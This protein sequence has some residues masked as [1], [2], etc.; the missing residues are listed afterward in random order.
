MRGVIRVLL[1]VLLVIMA[2][3]VG[4]QDELVVEPIDVPQFALSSV[5]P[6]G[7]TALGNGL[8]SR[9]AQPSE[10]DFTLFVLQSA[11]LAPATLMSALLPQLRLSEA[12]EPVETITNDFAEWTRYEI[13]VEGN[14]ITVA[15]D[16]AITNVNNV[17]YLVM[18]Q[19]A[20]QERDVLY[21][22]AFLPAVDALRPLVAEAEV[23]PYRV[24][25]VTFTN[26]DVTLS[27]TLTLP[28][29]EGRHPAVVLMTGSGP[30][31][32]DEEVIGGFPIFKQIADAFTRAG[33]AVLRYDDRGVGESGGVYEEASL[34]D[35]AADGQAAVDYLKTR[36]DI[37]TDEVG[38]L[39]HSEGGMY[40]AKIGA[41]P[42][43][44]VAFIILMASPTVDGMAVLIEQNRRI[45]E[46]SG[47]SQEQIDAQIRYLEALYPLAIARDWEAARQVTYDAVLEQFTMLSAEEQA[48]IGDAEARAEQQADAFIAGYGQEW[49]ASMLEYDPAPDF[50][51]VTVPMLALFGG[52]DVQVIAEQNI[53]PLEAII[54][55]NADAD[56]TIVT[57]PNA[58]HL[59]QEA[60][61]GNADEYTALPLAFTADFLPTMI[62]WLTARVTVVE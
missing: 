42:D 20:P 29:T 30:Q 15:V 23:V 61:T 54:A 41:N 2:S 40:A 48:A 43:S 22:Q 9:A 46:L 49:F 1:I 10:E 37:N 36:A 7:W 18:L 11:P 33:I 57:L 45:L 52:K 39:G 60:I 27:G 8:F 3:S 50:A 16:F 59:F 28:E 5:V 38:L 35:F 47:Q 6:Q 21:T 12:P 31:T 4:A 53:A 34:S 17:T 26:G 13:T 24:E 58:N 32:R 25:E 44:D 55:D 19:S 56:I 51:A 62:E 14:G